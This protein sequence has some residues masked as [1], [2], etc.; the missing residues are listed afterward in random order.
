M[1]ILDVVYAVLGQWFQSRYGVLGTLCLFFLGV[2]YRTR[3]TWCLSAGTM[4]LALLMLMPQ[5]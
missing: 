4:I 1:F 3:N 5:P 2:G